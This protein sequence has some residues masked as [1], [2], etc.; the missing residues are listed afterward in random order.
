LSSKQQA[1]GSNPFR[2]AMP[3]KHSGLCHCFL[4]NRSWVRIPSL[5]PYARSLRRSNLIG[6]AGPVSRAYRALRSEYEVVLVA[7]TCSCSTEVSVAVFQI[8]D[9]GSNPFTSTM[10]LWWNGIHACLRSTS[11]RMLV[12]IQSGVPYCKALAPEMRLKGATTGT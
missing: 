6:D 5:A 7:R 10:L 11:A 8:A 9:K 1:G 2:R 12:R 4:N 3:T